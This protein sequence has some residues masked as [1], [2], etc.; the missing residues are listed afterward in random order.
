MYFWPKHKLLFKHTTATP[1]LPV[2]WHIGGCKNYLLTVRPR[3]PPF[4]GVL[5]NAD[6][7][8]VQHMLQT[9]VLKSSQSVA[10]TIFFTYIIVLPHLISLV[11]F[12]SF[13]CSPGNVR[14]SL[15]YKTPYDSIQKN[16]LQTLCLPPGLAWFPVLFQ[17]S[18]RPRGQVQEVQL[19][20]GALLRGLASLPLSAE[21]I[22]VMKASH[23]V[24]FRS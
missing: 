23:T 17:P 4:V 11:Q 20:V 22:L 5:L 14:L 10:Y 24:A 7:P 1:F 19:P 13:A 12:V 2:V 6:H 16:K 18:R 8:L 3:T 15:H 9:T 21:R